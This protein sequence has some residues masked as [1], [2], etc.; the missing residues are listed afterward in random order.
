ML[1]N[2]NLFISYSFTFAQ[3][4]H[5]TVY[6]LEICEQSAISILNHIQNIMYKHDQFYIYKLF[7]NIIIWK[8]PLVKHISQFEI[9]I[10]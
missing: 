1:L 8:T 7:R 4:F 6:N 5:K 2:V 3:H 9:N 10:D